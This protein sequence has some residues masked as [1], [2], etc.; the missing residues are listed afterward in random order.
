MISFIIQLIL[1]GV[2]VFLSAKLLPGVH[3]SGLGTA[4]GVSI[5]LGFLNAV[6]RPV[7]TLLTLPITIVTLGFFWLVLNVLMV[8]I[9][10]A[11]FSGF[12]VDGF[13]W[14]LMFSFIL[15]LVNSILQSGKDK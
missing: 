2:A 6:V 15:S 8:Y 11:L 10:D 7:L 12:K 14:A 5:V 3:V 9:T 1:S 13:W 4:I